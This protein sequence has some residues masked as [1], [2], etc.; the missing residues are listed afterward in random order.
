MV[1]IGMTMLTLNSYASPNLDNLSPFEL[2]FGRK[3]KI[4]PQLEVTPELPVTDKLQ[5]A[6]TE[7][8]KKLQRA[9]KCLT[10]F[11]DKRLELWNKGKIPQGFQV[12]QLV[13]LYHGGGAL[14]QSGTRKIKSKFIG[15]LVI[16]RSISPNQFLL[17][18]LDGFVLPILVELGRIKAGIVRTSRGNVTTLSQLKQV[19]RSGFQFTDS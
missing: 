16:F 18:S 19:V 7:L 8:C 6:L 9:R 4:V 12:G 5:A 14:L 3:A 2:T 15:P 17:M 1:Q 13:Y 11:R 10:D